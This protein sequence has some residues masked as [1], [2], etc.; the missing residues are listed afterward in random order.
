MRIN[1]IYEPLDEPS[2]FAFTVRF[3][4]PCGA[5]S[6]DVFIPSASCQMQSVGDYIIVLV[7]ALAMEMEEL[8]SMIQNAVV[9]C[10]DSDYTGKELNPVLTS[11]LVEVPS[12]LNGSRFHALHNYY[13]D[14]FAM[15]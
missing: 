4:N 5:S 10:D 15:S 12:S 11:G 7:T 3:N 1:D 13:P 14:F 9:S 6:V 8:Q 2:A